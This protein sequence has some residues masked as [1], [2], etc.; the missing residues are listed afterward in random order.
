[1][2]GWK[3]LEFTS[4]VKTTFLA[5]C[6]FLCVALAPFHGEAATPVIW[7]NQN[8][9][10]FWNDPVNWGILN[11]P[12]YN[13]APV[14]GDTAI[15]RSSSPTGTITLT[16]HGFCARI[17]QDVGAV[18]RTVTI[19]SGQT[20]DRILTLDG[21]AAEL[22]DFTAANTSFTIDG[23]PNGNGAKLKLVVNGKNRAC[24]INSDATLTLNCDVSGT[25][26]F[27]LNTGDNGGGTLFLNGVNTYTGPTT[28][29]AGLL[30]LN[31]K[32]SPGAVTVNGGALWG[33]GTIAGPVVVAGGAKI[34]AGFG[35][36]ELTLAAGLDMSATVNDPINVWELAAFKDDATGVPGAD[37]DQIVVTG[38][39]LNLGTESLLDIRFVGSATRPGDGNPF[40]Q[41]SHSWTVIRLNGGTNPG[42]FNFGSIKNARSCAGTFTTAATTNGIVLTFTPLPP[43]T[44]PRI[45]AVSFA[46]PGSATV[47]YT[48][49]LPG[50]NYVLAYRTN[51]NATNWFTAGSK[52][53]A[54]T[55]D[56]Q[57]DTAATNSQRFY[58]FHY[59][60]PAQLNLMTYNI[61]SARHNA[62]QQSVLQELE[63]I[64]QVIE[65]NQ[66]D[67]LMLQEVMRFDPY[68]N[69]VDEFTWLQQRLGYPSAR[70][71]S[72]Q[73]DP[74]PPG[75]A[76]WGVAVY[77]RNGQITSTQKHLLGYNRVLFRVTAFI[78]GTNVAFYCTHLQPGQVAQ[79]A[80]QVRQILA[81][82][83]PPQPIILGGDFNAGPLSTDLSPIRT[84]LGNVFDGF[85]E[86]PIDSFFISANVGLMCA[87]VVP[88]PSEASDHEPVISFLKIPIH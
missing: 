39:T 32:S 76:E 9:N 4:A 17:R 72:G 13:V 47:N 27:T 50:T 77:L 56:F 66:P 48:N 52:T 75:T 79:Q 44:A 23:T 34:A 71:A 3:Q 37:F 30:K 35:V 29:N 62:T 58:R 78:G 26:G 16:N 31:G 22:F 36:G 19:H 46:G 84:I 70:Y 63:N 51:L 64:A 53:A 57:S 5:A 88:D 20:V 40:W 2:T 69:Y 21:T 61:Q 18:N 1:V 14:A 67:V 49:T 86:Q 73:A 80:E 24:A 85:E 60:E 28:V 15:F 11:N 6:T 55:S 41:T 68:V 8:G 54:G 43:P 33:Q 83:T 81:A 12:G 10:G 7:D 45:T 82:H 42:P 65:R 59:R 25:N 74:V 87:Q 38:G